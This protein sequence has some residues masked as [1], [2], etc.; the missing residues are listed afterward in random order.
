MLTK[1]QR[2]KGRQSRLQWFSIQVH[3]W[4]V[5]CKPIIKG[6]T[7]EDGLTY[8]NICRSPERGGGTA[9]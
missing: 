3:L 2:E 7:K 8:N 1:R 4:R 6:L 5:W 9:E